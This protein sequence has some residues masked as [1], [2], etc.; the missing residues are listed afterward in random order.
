[1]SVFGTCKRLSNSNIIPAAD[2]EVVSKVAANLLRIP[3]LF[4]PFCIGQ[5]VYYDNYILET[6]WI[7][8]TREIDGT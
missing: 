2:A 3:T 7:H 1:M 6:I 4:N 5:I 8:Q